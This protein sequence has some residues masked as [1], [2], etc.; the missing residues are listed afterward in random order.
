MVEELMYDKNNFPTGR[1]FATFSNN[2]PYLKAVKEY[3]QTKN[4]LI[5]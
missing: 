2:N 3:Q 4:L 5:K 1:L